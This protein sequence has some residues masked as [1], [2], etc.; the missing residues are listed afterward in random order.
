MSGRVGSLLDRTRPC[1]RVV[2]WQRYASIADH[3]GQRARIRDQPRSAVRKV[4]ELVS[5]EDTEV[6]VVPGGHM[7]MFGGRRAVSEVM[8]ASAEWLA[9]RST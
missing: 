1:R 7:G 3:F 4:A 5:S 9:T 6:R 2:G 8:E